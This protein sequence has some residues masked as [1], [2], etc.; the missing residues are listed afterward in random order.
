MITL[1]EEWYDS[2]SVSSRSGPPAY[3]G[4]NA[5]KAKLVFTRIVL[6]ALKHGGHGV[7]ES[8][9]EQTHCGRVR[10]VEGLE[11]LE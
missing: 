9:N 6:Q 7:R 5:H 4:S 8:G 11:L 3:N 1:E 10:V 2:G